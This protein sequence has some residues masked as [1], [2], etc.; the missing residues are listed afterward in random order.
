MLMSGLTTI[1]GIVGAAVAVGTL[2][3]WITSSTKKYFRRLDGQITGKV[4]Q[5]SNRVD[6]LETHLTRLDGNLTMMALG[7]SHIL[8]SLEVKEGHD[9][10]DVIRDM[11]TQLTSIV[12]E[13]I[14]LESVLHN[15]LSPEEL[16]RMQQYHD[17]IAAGHPL[18]EDQ[19]RD[20][21]GLAE[22]MKADHPDEPVFNSLLL[23]TALL[24]AI[25]LLQKK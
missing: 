19:A 24:L 5:V 1:E 20:M 12:R 10:Q 7:F 15:P 21:N 8:P 22:R 17:V 11:R 14:R 9:M 3:I 16:E 4:D 2:G 13:S 23:V 18:S 25:A 6:H